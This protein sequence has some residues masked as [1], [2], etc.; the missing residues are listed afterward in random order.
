MPLLQASTF[1]LSPIAYIRNK[2]GGPAFKYLT[3][4]CICQNG[5]LVY[6]HL[7]GSVTVL[8]ML[9][10]ACEIVEICLVWLPFPEVT[11]FKCSFLKHLITPVARR[12]PL[13]LPSVRDS[14]SA[15]HPGECLIRK[16]MST[17][18]RLRVPLS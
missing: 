4:A 2:Y 12:L 6:H 18:R 17:A 7:H 5:C 15:P 11:F 13:F 1:P 16:G 9:V 8:F 3:Y 14:L 10:V